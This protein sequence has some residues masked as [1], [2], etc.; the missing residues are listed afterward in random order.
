MKDQ[1]SP[2]TGD[3][4]TRSLGAPPRRS[5]LTISK[6]AA[7]AGV[8]LYLLHL[9]IIQVLSQNVQRLEERVQTLERE[10][11]ALTRKLEILNVVDKHQRGFSRGEITRLVSVIDGESRRFGIDPLL[12]LAVIL[13]ES[14]FKRFEVSEKG[15]VGLMQIRPFVGRDLALRRGITWNEQVGL[16][17]PELNVKLGTTYLFEL[18]LKFNDLAYALAAYAHGETQMQKQLQLGRPAPRSYSRRV[19][20][21]YETLVAEFRLKEATG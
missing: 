20:S 10:N 9:G 3:Q 12:I 14:E 11:S 16:F 15:A 17:D 5:G 21:R 1:E 19:L 2:E 4:G 7:V 8:L 6:S 18:I 13:T